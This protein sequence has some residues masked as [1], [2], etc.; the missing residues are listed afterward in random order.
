MWVNQ[1]FRFEL[2]PNAA[3]RQAILQHIGAA[4]FAYNWGL[5][6]VTKALEKK[7]KIPSAPELHKMWNVWKKDN[8]PWWKEV[9]KCAPQEAFRDLEKGIKRWKAKQSRLPKFKKK[10]LIPDNSVRFTGSIRVFEATFRFQ[11]LAE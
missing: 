6:I 8:A 9:S 1:A 11:G 5:E 2:E 4:R 10:K 7:E 3:Q